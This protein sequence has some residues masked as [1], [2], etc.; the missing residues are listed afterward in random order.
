ME[1]EIKPRMYLAACILGVLAACGGSSD[2]YEAAVDAANAKQAQAVSLAS[3]M[4]CSNVSQCNVLRFVPPTGRCSCVSY[5]A[6]SLIS[7]TADLA[8]LAA[9]E[10]NELAMTARSIG[11]L[12]EVCYCPGP[13]LMTCSAASECALAQ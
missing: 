5:Q 12:S 8:R 11:G 13:P 9:T 7:S 1:A 2:S 3:A 10:Q 6:Y 4:P